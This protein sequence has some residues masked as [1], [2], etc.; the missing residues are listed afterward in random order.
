MFISGDEIEGLVLVHEACYR[1]LNL[2]LALRRHL[3]V[4]SERLLSV[5]LG[6]A[7]KI[8][9]FS[10]RHNGQCLEPLRY[11]GARP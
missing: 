10:V 8:E 4:I 6:S 3:A 2:N 11:A 9:G 5:E 1:F 7:F